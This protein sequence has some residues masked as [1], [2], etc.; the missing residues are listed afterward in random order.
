MS[1]AE[2][3]SDFVGNLAI[4]NAEMIGTRYGELTSALNK[5]FRDTE[6]KTAN[7]LQVVVHGRFWCRRTVL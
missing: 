4:S 6:S 7:T 2:M 1:V 5:R 3:F